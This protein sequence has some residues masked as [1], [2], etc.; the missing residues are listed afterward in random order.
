MGYFVGKCVFVL[1]NFFDIIGVKSVG[2][3][4]IWVKWN[5]VIIFD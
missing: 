4:V 1:G 3:G 2:M 5:F